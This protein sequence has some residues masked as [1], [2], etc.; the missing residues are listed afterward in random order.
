MKKKL[1]KRTKFAIAAVSAIVLYTVAVLILSY[2]DHTVP[3]ELTQ[4]FFK[5]WTVELALLFG[6]KILDK[7]KGDGL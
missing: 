1:K 6:I 2:F 7:D 3:Q 4:S 5:A